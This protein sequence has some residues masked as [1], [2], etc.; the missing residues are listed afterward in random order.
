MSKSDTTNPHTTWQRS[1]I[2]HVADVLHL[3][4]SSPLDLPDALK[5]RISSLR[6]ALIAEAERVMKGL[7]NE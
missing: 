3:A 5:E 1:M 2:S 7:P 6:E 4:E